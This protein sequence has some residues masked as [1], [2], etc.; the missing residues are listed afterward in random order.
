[1]FLYEKAKKDYGNKVLANGYE[2][3]NKYAIVV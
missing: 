2:L 3:S 1:M